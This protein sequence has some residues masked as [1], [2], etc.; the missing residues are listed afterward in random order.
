MRATAPSA[1][2]PQLPSTS[3]IIDAELFS[4]TCDFVYENGKK[5]GD[6]YVLRTGF[7]A[8]F[9]PLKIG[10]EMPGL[11][12]MGAHSRITRLYICAGLGDFNSD[13]LEDILYA[14]T[15]AVLSGLVPGDFAEEMVE[16]IEFET[17]H[18]PA[19]KTREI[20]FK[21]RDEIGPEKIREMFLRAL[22]AEK[23]SA[24]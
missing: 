15:R 3:G 11:F 17:S 12:T 19:E 13:Y 23:G 8:V 5:E 10:A 1:A 4:R 7:W 22:E 6:S 20:V 16:E 14:N 9:V 2:L 24:A 21:V 18:L